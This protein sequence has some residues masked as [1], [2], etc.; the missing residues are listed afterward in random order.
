MCVCVWIVSFPSQLF[1]TELVRQ[2]I[3]GASKTGRGYC[4]FF[5]IYDLVYGCCSNVP[6]VPTIRSTLHITRDCSQQRSDMN[7]IMAWLMANLSF[8]AIE[9]LCVVG[10][11]CAF[12]CVAWIAA[13]ATMSDAHGYQKLDYHTAY[14]IVCPSKSISFSGNRQTESVVVS[15][16]CGWR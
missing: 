16:D 4:R 8:V 6:T 5:F 2:T 13:A 14:S 10:L 12:W 11:L 7:M 9:E 3:G 15:C 1:R